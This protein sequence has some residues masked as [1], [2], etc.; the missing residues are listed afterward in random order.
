MNTSI[1][2]IYTVEE[3]QENFDE[4]FERV[5]DGETFQIQGPSGNVCMIVPAE[6]AIYFNH[7]DAS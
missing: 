3:F 6:Y 5:L 1:E 4:L 7:N 2:K